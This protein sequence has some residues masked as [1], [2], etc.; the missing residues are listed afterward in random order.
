MYIL[1]EVIRA[2]KVRDGLVAIQLD[3]AKA[4]DTAPHE[5]IDADLKRMGLPSGARESIMNSYKSL[6][7]TIEHSGSKSEVSLMIGV[8]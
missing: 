8:K 3:I 7:T 2:V 6:S 4:F 1:N 5:A